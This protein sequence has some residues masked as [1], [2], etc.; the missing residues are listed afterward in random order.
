MARAN[1][2]CRILP[3][4]SQ[5]E[6]RQKLIQIFGD[7]KLAVNYVNDAGEVLGLGSAKKSMEPPA[8]P[9]GRLRAAAE[10]D[11]GDV[12]GAAG[13]AD[14]VDRGERLNHHHGGWNSELRDQRDGCGF[15]R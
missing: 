4:H 5:E 1:V 7:P 8:G 9:G 13:G 15:R 3:G 12:A 2:N 6:I 14:D 10:G 11:A